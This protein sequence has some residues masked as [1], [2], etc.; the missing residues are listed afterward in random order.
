MITKKRIGFLIFIVLLVVVLFYIG[1]TDV[2]NKG[3]D[4]SSVE[5]VTTDEAVTDDGYNVEYD[6]NG[7]MTPESMQNIVN[8]EMHK[9]AYP[10]LTEEEKMEIY[11]EI[12]E[13]EAADEYEPPTGA[14][15]W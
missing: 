2:A 8:Q 10:E 5:D 3:S 7:N 9:E 4:S 1:T 15:P 12:M 13:Q 14:K 6:E 11:S